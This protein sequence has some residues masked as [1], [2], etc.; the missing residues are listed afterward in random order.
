MKSGQAIQRQLALA[1][2]LVLV[3]QQLEL[4]FLLDRQELSLVCLLSL[5]GSKVLV[6]SVAS[7]AR[8]RA[9]AR[10]TTSTRAD[11]VG[12]ATPR[13]PRPTG[14]HGPS[15]CQLAA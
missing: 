1:T 5:G 4:S 6:M 7:I 9:R 2:G 14:A 3:Q 8:D 12:V 15:A 13:H 10:T 11:T